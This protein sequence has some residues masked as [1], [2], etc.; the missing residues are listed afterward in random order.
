MDHVLDRYHSM[1]VEQNQPYNHIP[2]ESSWPSD[3]NLQ[4]FLANRYIF[5]FPHKQIRL[6]RLSKSYSSLENAYASHHLKKPIDW[7]EMHN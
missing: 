5:I 6:I 2:G 7:V 4:Q 1:I 3:L